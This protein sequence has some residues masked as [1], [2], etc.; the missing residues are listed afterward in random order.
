MTTSL[1]VSAALSLAAAAI[2]ARAGYLLMV[3][4]AATAD[5][6]LASAMFGIWWLGLAANSTFTATTKAMAA[7]RHLRLPMAIALQFLSLT[8][9]CIALWA[10]LYYM[11]FLFTG[12][13]AFFWPLAILY[14]GFDAWLLQA[15][16]SW[17][18][19][20]LHISGWQ[21]SLVYGDPARGSAL[22]LLGA[23]LLGPQI[24][25]ALALY[26]LSVRLPRGAPR[27]RVI[28]VATGILF[29]FGSALTGSATGIHSSEMWS[30]LQQVIGMGVATAILLVYRPAAKARENPTS[31]PGH[32][33]E[34][35]ATTS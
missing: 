4:H 10:L 5:D 13:R 34:S 7:L 29:W 9:V 12:N 28:V 19:A 16:A 22:I 31:G 23:L 35:Q 14:T 26:G 15:V 24:L 11:T 6:R 1:L 27:R 2:F 8:A 30:A 25:T 33:A 20:A 17:G 21:V 18:P 3:R 32:K